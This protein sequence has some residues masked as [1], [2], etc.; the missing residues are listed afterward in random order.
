VIYSRSKSNTI[1]I[2]IQNQYVKQGR[3]DNDIR[4]KGYVENRVL[5]V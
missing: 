5:I 3:M 2:T 4:L 1:T